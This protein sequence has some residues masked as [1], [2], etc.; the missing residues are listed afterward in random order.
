VKSRTKPFWS[1]NSILE[2]E[3]D[4]SNTIAI[5]SGFPHLQSV[6]GANVASEKVA[7]AQLEKT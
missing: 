4:L 5:S 7:A 2:I 6:G 3:E 1:L